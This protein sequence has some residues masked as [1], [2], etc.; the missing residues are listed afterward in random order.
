MKS[1]K[2]SMRI[3]SVF[4]VLIILGVLTPM[5]ANASVTPNYVDFGEVEVGSSSTTTLLLTN[6]NN[7]P[8]DVTISIVGD[9]CG[10]STNVRS[11]FLAANGRGII[12][13]S[14]A[15]YEAKSCSA[16]LIVGITITRSTERVPLSGTGI[17][18]PP[19]PPTTIVIG[20]VDTGIIDTMFEDQLIS[21]Q[22]EQCA[23]G[24]RNHGQFVSCVVHLANELKREG[25]ITKEEM[26]TMKTCAARSRI[27]R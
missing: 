21:A 13:V 16:T 8:I 23:I 27:P 26:K 7:V 19:P 4:L 14:Y 20:D 25:I 12:E 5:V 22:I 2:G 1:M 18:P 10:F 6:T 15:P 24:A 17:I 9:E 11:L 3:I